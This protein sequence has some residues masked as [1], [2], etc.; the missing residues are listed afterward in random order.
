MNSKNS[1]TVMNTAPVSGVV[2]AHKAEEGLE[3]RLTKRRRFLAKLG[4]REGGVSN[5]K[6]VSGG[7]F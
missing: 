4:N 2:R 5:E 6:K 1:F 7:D 3:K